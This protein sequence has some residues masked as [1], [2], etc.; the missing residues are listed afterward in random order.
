MKAQGFQMTQVALSPRIMA[1]AAAPQLNFVVCSTSSILNLGLPPASVGLIS[2]LKLQAHPAAELR[3][4]DCVA[5]C[6]GSC[7]SNVAHQQPLTTGF[8]FNKRLP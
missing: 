5:G 4:D 3:Y 6:G 2:T 8:N 7:G 1:N